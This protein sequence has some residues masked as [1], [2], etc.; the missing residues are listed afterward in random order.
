MKK[1][2]LPLLLILIGCS[3]PVDFNSLVEREGLYYL[4]H[5]NEP[6]S[7]PVDGSINVHIKEGKLHG[8][9]KRYYFFTV[10]L[11]EEGT[12]KDGKRHGPSISY[13]LN[14][15]LWIKVTYKDDKWDGP[16]KQYDENGELEFEYTYKD[17]E[18]IDSK[19]YDES[20]QLT[21]E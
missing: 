21:V 15:Q 20:G 2:L 14:G 13:H 19:E 18:L 7:G 4:R 16:Y 11:K 3:E 10:K 1:L 8:P 9:F 5:T 17:G 12:Y 6:Y